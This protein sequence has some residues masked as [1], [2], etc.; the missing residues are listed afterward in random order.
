MVRPDG[1]LGQRGCGPVVMINP[2]V[3]M[4]RWHKMGI[5]SP[6]RSLDLCSHGA[7]P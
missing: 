7:D 3:F 2:E 6:T 5:E 1:V 4:I